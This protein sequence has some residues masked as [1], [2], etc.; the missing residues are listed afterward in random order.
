MSSEP[1]ECLNCG[2][3]LSGPYCGRCGQKAA[4]LELTMREFLGTALQD[5]ISLDSRVARTLTLLILR[6]GEVTARYLAG[7]RARFVPPVRLYLFV[8]VGYFLLLSWLGGGIGPDVRAADGTG[9]PATVAEQVRTEL[10]E[11]VREESLMNALTLQAGIAAQDPEGF[12]RRLVE[13]ASYLMFLLLPAFA[14]LSWLLFRR[15]QRY[16]LHHLLHALH[17]H[18]FAYLALGVAILL[19]WP[20][21]AVLRVAGELVPVAIPIH[22]LV[23]FRRMH[24]ESWWA[25]VLKTGVLCGVYGLLLLVSVVALVVLV[26]IL[27]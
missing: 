10:E 24:G 15:R 6:P 5:A 16:Y 8:S 20:G 2:A 19:A 9:D 25:T 14:G 26:L 7:E 13:G 4:E 18:V 1:Q 23:S 12:R 27:A 17:L 11:G 21:S 3:A 22:V